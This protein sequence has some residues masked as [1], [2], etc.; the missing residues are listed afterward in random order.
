MSIAQLSARTGVSPATLRTWELRYGA[1]RPRRLA[2]GHRR[3]HEQDVDLI[4]E[5]LRQRAGG[6]SLPAAIQAA[7]RSTQSVDVS[8]FAG[9]RLRHPE[10][11]PSVLQKATLIGLSHAL[12]DECCA[13]ATRPVL[14]ASFQRRS[15]YLPARRRWVDLA[16]TAANTTVFV[17]FDRAS[18]SDGS[19]I[20]VPIPVDAPLSREWVIICDAVDYAACL[21]G[22]ERPGQDAQPDRR[23][24]FE[25]LVTLDPHAVADAAGIAA[26]LARRFSPE[27]ANALPVG[28]TA[29]GPVASMELRRASDLFRRML[30]YVDQA[31]AT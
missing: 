21:V 10:L 27:A 22:W 23:R 7:A 30:T 4:R 11:A 16:R 29:P 9:L 17:E 18:R 12:E 1:P 5:V 26:D 24:R 19:L 25:T 14:F 31:N 6:V 2:G 8:I 15:F 3:Y 28:T 20:E 13:R